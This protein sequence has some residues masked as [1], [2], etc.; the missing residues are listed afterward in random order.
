MNM[1][2]SD[3]GRELG[4]KQL[5]ERFGPFEAA[6]EKARAVKPETSY[7]RTVPPEQRATNGL[8][9]KYVAERDAALRA[10][11]DLDGPAKQYIR[12]LNAHYKAEFA[13]VKNWRT[14][15]FDP[16]IRIQTLKR[17]RERDMARFLA[18]TKAQRADLASNRPVKSWPEWLRDEA[19]KG[20]Q[21]AADELRRQAAKVERFT[22]VLV[23]TPP[24]AAR[25]VRDLDLK[26][27]ATRGGDIVYR[28][29]DGGTVVD[30][31]DGLQMP[32]A[33]R[34]AAVMILDMARERAGNQPL[35]VNGTMEQAAA[36][37]E[38]AVQLRADITFADPGLEAERQR[39]MAEPIE[40]QGRRIYLSIPYA[41]RE[42]ARELGAR[43]DKE[44]K[45][46]WISPSA[47]PASF[48][49]W[50][51]DITAVVRSKILTDFIADRSKWREP[52]DTTEWR[53]M[54]VE[55]QGMARFVSA[56]K[57]GAAEIAVWRTNGETIVQDITGFDAS[58]ARFAYPGMF[59][60]LQ[61]VM[62]PEM[63]G[64][65]EREEAQQKAE[66]PMPEPEEV[67]GMAG[68]GTEET[69]I[70]M[71]P[72]VPEAGADKG[73]EYEP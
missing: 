1:K 6:G 3:L 67:A 66:A 39:R 53:E 25:V 10:R 30:K 29:P 18:R 8:W 34:A 26:P 5:V 51:E 12:D 55:D 73:V 13:K 15:M 57:V 65:L 50:H 62:T 70:P 54:S 22:N 46:W 9:E 2:A 56:F 40:A 14:E 16:R 71:P 36:I 35:S 64:E 63:H 28:M 7:T 52:G 48:A 32:M 31:K 24:G 49:K 59:A 21:A 42:K 41:E 61:N 43:W 60:D 38:A 47:D 33:S 58:P 19:G 27:K 45:A 72:P 23:R 11:A 68:A 69:D 4:Y 20:N 37:M 17:N 44:A